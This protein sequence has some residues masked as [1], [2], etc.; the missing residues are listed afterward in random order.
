MVKFMCSVCLA[1]DYHSIVVESLFESWTALNQGS[2][3]IERAKIGPFFGEAWAHSW[4]LERRGQLLV[5]RQR[6]VTEK[7]LPLWRPGVLQSSA[8]PLFSDKHK[9]AELATC[10]TKNM[11]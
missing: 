1:E 10:V 4:L 7:H 11:A 2:I 9:R 6:G 8:S 3:R 5:F